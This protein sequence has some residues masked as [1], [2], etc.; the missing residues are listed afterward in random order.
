MF[1][2]RAQAGRILADKL[3]PYTVATPVVIAINRGGLAVAEP[4]A[5]AL[6]APLD[7]VLTRPIVPSEDEPAIGVVAVG[8]GVSLDDAAVRRTGFDGRHLLD[9]I[10]R[11]RASL[12][13]PNASARG[14][15]PFP[16]VAGRLVIVV[17]DSVGTIHDELAAVRTIRSRRPR[18]I[19]FATPF[20]PL[21]SRGVLLPEVETV[22]T[23]STSV[24]TGSVYE[25]VRHPDDAQTFAVLGGSLKGHEDERERLYHGAE[26]GDLRESPAH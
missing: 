5:R 3:L 4:I 22:M 18:W 14:D 6:R 11:T 9:F 2:D 10:E 8:G 25:D 16:D 15:L 1:S 26:I 24:P 17:S 20:F 12:D 21:S 7:V 13:R 23:I 19:V